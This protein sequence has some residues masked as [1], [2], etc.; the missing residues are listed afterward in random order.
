MKFNCELWG[1]D[2]RRKNCEWKMCDGYKARGDN[3]STH[4]HDSHTYTYIDL[5]LKADWYIHNLRH[6]LLI[7]VCF[8]F[9]SCSSVVVW[10]RLIYVTSTRIAYIQREL[11]PLSN[12]NVSLEYWGEMILYWNYV[13]RRSHIWSS[14]RQFVF[15][16]QESISTFVYYVLDNAKI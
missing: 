11:P 15:A 3:Y 16:F 7:I 9:S 14:N 1:S 5:S 8:F 4:P 2:R 12:R 10:M 6:Y 13:L